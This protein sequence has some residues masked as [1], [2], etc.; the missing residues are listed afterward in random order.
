MIS[1]ENLSK[2]ISGKE[3]IKHVDFRLRSNM[4]TALLGMNG[5]GKTTT[6]HMLATILKPSAGRVVMHEAVK[7]ARKEIGFLPQHPTFHGWMSAREYVTMAGELGGLS[8]GDAN[9]RADEVLMQTGLERSAAQRIS[10]FSGGM[11]QRL[12]IAQAIIH[13]PKLLLLDEP[14]SSLDPQGRKDVISLLSELKKKTTI[15]YSTHILHDAEQIA[16]DVLMM[17]KGK[18]VAFERL[19]ELMQQSSNRTKFTVHAEELLDDWGVKLQKRYPDWTIHVRESKADIEGPI[20]G[21][22]M[23]AKVMESLVENRVAIRSLIAGEGSLDELF[24]EVIK[25]V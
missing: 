1:V 17:H 22:E 14:V 23:Q 15:L 11:K 21:V 2:N 12:G 7:D 20:E 6:L 18:I 13:R 5:A 24:R 8:R 3:I 10:E 4:I 16:D 25:R 9:V 19:D